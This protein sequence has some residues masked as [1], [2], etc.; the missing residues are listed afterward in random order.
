MNPR[1]VP[2]AGG[3]IRIGHALGGGD[4]KRPRQGFGNLRRAHGGERADLALAV[5]FEKAGERARAGER[6]HQRAAADVFGAPRRHEGA[7]V[8]RHKRGELLERR[9]AAKV[10]GEEGEE[11]QN[12]APVGFESLRRHAAFGAEITEPAFDLGGD[13][14]RQEGR[15]PA[16]SRA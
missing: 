16:L 10:V 12:V 3:Q 7:H 15:Q 1:R 8:G 13:L 14:G 11:L 6:A 5:A 9:R 2:V 4:G